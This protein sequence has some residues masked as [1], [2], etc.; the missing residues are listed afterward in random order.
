MTMTWTTQASLKDVDACFRCPLWNGEY[1]TCQV[2]HSEGETHTDDT[3]PPDWCP[4][5]KG[6]VTIRLATMRDPVTHCY[7]CPFSGPRGC[8]LDEEVITTPQDQN[9][10]DD[11]PIRSGPV[12]V[13]YRERERCT[14]TKLGQ[15]CV[16]VGGHESWPDDILRLENIHAKHRAE[17]DGAVVTWGGDDD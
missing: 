15:R 8:T 9:P 10:P 4:L 12:T 5:R 17:N 11:C 6:P 16:H 1:S 13:T 14:A 3:N 7:D 2:A